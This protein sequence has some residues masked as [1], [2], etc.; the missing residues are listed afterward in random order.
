MKQQKGRYTTLKV[1][2]DQRRRLCKVPGS[3]L[4]DT[5]G[6]APGSNLVTKHEMTFRSNL[7][8]TIN[9]GPHVSG[10]AS[11]TVA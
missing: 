7:V 3:N 8:N 11:L 1:V 6:R 5:L 10:D 4:T 9:D 2:H